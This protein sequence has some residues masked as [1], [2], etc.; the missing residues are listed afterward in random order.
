MIRISIALVTAVVAAALAAPVHGGRPRG[1]Y[2]AFAAL[3]PAEPRA[4]NPE[5]NVP[6]HCYVAVRGSRAGEGM[7]NTCWT[8]HTVPIVDTNLQR[9]WDLQRD[10]SFSP[11]AQEN[12]WRTSF[13]DRRAAVA[14]VDDA[15]VR[16]YVR[17]DNYRA[18]REALA[19]DRAY[20]GFRPDVDLDRGYD[21]DG[22]ARDGS[23][24]R[25]VRYKPFPVVGWPGGGG[26]GE[27][28]VR[29]PRGFREDASGRPSRVVYQANLAIL[30]LAVAADP[31]AP[32]ER[33][34]RPTD[35]LDE[36][37]L[38]QDLDGDGHL[39][40]ATHLVG[41]P[42]HYLGGAANVAVVRNAYPA[43]TEFLHPVR[44]L[45]PESPTYG[46]RRMKELRYA[47]K[48]RVLGD[49]AL[50]AAY[51]H[52]A[53]EKAEGRPPVYQGEPSTGLA[54]PLGW[55]FQGFIEEAAGRLRAQ[56]DAE[57]RPCL[58]CHSGLGVTVDQTFAFPRKVPGPQGFRPQDL[59]G[60]KDW[61]QL[62]HGDPE[63]LTYF[64]RAGRADPFGADD[65]AE[66]RFFPHGVLDEA[67][68][69]R[70][71][72]GGDRDLAWLLQPSPARAWALDKA[73]LLVVR[74]QRFEE[75]RDVRPEA[76]LRLLR[77]AEAGPTG[78]DADAI[79]TDGR[80]H[81]AF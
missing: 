36:R 4:P 8:C 42:G 24:W 51:E 66:E 7:S 58:G 44:Y 53:A 41:L 63:I 32:R 13:V 5:P 10:Y 34:T 3:V 6:V 80:V 71:A 29:L 72:P 12:H 47:Q 20:R 75:G 57:L 16:A 73:Y 56:T 68:V 79:F 28:L 65:E 19:D 25:A 61:P 74:A 54:S 59:R 21:A 31:R 17:G 38:G 23:D 40:I 55:R 62:G 22:F 81:L 2:D 30:E 43:G 69:R 39:G 76:A 1:E 37:S 49:W 46:A 18:L 9:D 78:L 45:D 26:A 50:G 52:E 77:R 60:M 48:M 15:M 64:R 67:G 11:A 33:V 14:T 70:G 27:L 35:P